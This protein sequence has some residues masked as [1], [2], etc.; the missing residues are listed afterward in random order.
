VSHPGEDPRVAPH[1]VVDVEQSDAPPPI[2]PAEMPRDAL[3]KIVDEG[4]IQ[5]VETA[6][7]EQNIRLPMVL[8][9]LDRVLDAGFGNLGAAL[10]TMLVSSFHLAR[11]DKLA[12]RVLAHADTAGSE[13][14]TDLSAA[15]MMQERLTIAGKVV[16]AV[17]ARDPTHGR[18]L[19]LKA[20]L[21]ARRGRIDQAF[22]TIA[23]VSPKL[24]D[25][26]GMAVQARYALLAQRERAIDGALKLAKK[27][28]DP[29]TRARV[30]EVE[31]MRDR[32]DRAPREIVAAAKTDLR[33][34]CALEYGALLVEL[35]ADPGDGGRF[36]MDAIAVRDAGR[37]I[38]RMLDAI[39]RIE[40]PMNECLYATEDGEIVAAAINKIT[41]KP[42]RE[43]RA[44]RPGADGS[45]L[46]MASAATH[47]HLPNAV[48][49]TIQRA[50][51]E[52]TVRTLAL[53]LP[54][55]WRGPLV[56]DVIGRI[57]GDDEL[58][59]TVDDEV[60]E[61]LERI[62]GEDEEM[63]AGLARDDDGEIRAHAERAK[64]ILRAT[65]KL[66]RP[67]HVPFLDETPIPRE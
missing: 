52:G 25:A 11:A 2:P 6:L 60:D 65:A 35:A 56:P 37:L 16:D 10:I 29:D 28:D 66:P 19:Y 55:G 26:D 32:F 61:V 18:A 48:V 1:G 51:D 41:G 63:T 36:G 44:D 67:A 57:T 40:A 54:C 15:L 43:W 14:L 49:E 53:V 45:W 42:C 23:R 8:D 12:E 4:N 21:F 39:A 3:A 62:F 64:S 31:R 24:L 58:P 17:L 22:D 9:E 46:C 59:W 47:P 33:A 7:R 38:G 50:L 13:E 34:I 27:S 30:A 5:A 20:R